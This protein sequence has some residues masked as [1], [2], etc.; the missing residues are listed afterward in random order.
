MYR[1]AQ[2]PSLAELSIFCLYHN[3]NRGPEMIWEFVQAK[4]DGHKAQ[5][6]LEKPVLM[7]GEVK[8][9]ADRL[10]KNKG[11]R[12]GKAQGQQCQ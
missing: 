8:E 9:D 7:A 10:K 2:E 4:R 12:R 11:R 3:V 5:R 1:I 6:H